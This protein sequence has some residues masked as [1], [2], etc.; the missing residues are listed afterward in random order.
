MTVLATPLLVTGIGLMIIRF[1]DR[2]MAFAS[3][4]RPILFA[5]GTLA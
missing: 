3:A 2:R 4:I 5:A 1:R